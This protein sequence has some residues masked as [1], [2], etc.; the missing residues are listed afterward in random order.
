ML[1]FREVGG[2]VLGNF[3]Y[4]SFNFSASL[5]VFQNKKLRRN[6]PRPKPFIN[7]PVKISFKNQFILK[8]AHHYR[9]I[10]CSSPK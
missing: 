1:T 3:L 7:F 8:S 6:V 5:K 2:K 10:P 9:V 4:Y